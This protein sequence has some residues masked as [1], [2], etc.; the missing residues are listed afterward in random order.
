M[1]IAARSSQDFACCSRATASAR[2]K[3]ASAL[4]AS[5]SGASSA[6]SPAMRWTSASHHVSLVVSTAV[7]ASPMQRQASSNWPSSAWALAKYDKVRWHKRCCSRGPKCGDPGAYHLDCVR[8]FAG[9]SQYTTLQQHSVRFPKKKHLFHT[10]TRQVRLRHPLAAP[11]TAPRRSPGVIEAG[12]AAVSMILWQA[13]AHENGRR[14][15]NL[16]PPPAGTGTLLQRRGFV[17]L[18]GSHRLQ[19]LAFMID[20]A[21]EVAELPPAIVR[22]S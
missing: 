12:T 10:P 21:Q 2:S 22:C 15:P 4:A 1:L 13:F 20:R 14:S 19:D 5:G 8:G 6:I 18:R 17:S 9:Q 11:S 3:Y 16:S 7:I